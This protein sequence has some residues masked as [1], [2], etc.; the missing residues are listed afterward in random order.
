MQLSQ[1]VPKL[2]ENVSMALPAMTLFP[3]GGSVGMVLQVLASSAHES[4]METSEE[5]GGAVRMEQTSASTPP[6]V[7]T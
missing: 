5:T 6:V 1:L 4:S 3:G 2:N 7:P